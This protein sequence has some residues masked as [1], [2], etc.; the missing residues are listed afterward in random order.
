MLEES[1]IR[2]NLVEGKHADSHGRQQSL[3]FQTFSKIVKKK[4]ISGKTEVPISSTDN[5]DGNAQLP[6]TFE[7]AADDKISVDVREKMMG[8]FTRKLAVEQ[9]DNQLQ[10]FRS[11]CRS[12]PDSAKFDEPVTDDPANL[13]GSNISEVLEKMMISE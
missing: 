3:S 7:G 4:V 8:D 11:L 6:N 1:G 12:L 2:C 13:V 9:S 10:Q 5:E